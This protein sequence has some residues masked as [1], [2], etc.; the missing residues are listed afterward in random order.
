MMDG[1]IRKENSIAR[2]RSTLHIPVDR[3]CRFNMGY[4]MIVLQDVIESINNSP[5][6]EGW[7][8]GGVVE[9]GWSNRDADLIVPNPKV[10][11]SLPSYFDVIV[12]EGKPEGP[13]IPVTGLKELLALQ[14]QQALDGFR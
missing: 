1:S 12:Q 5:L 14:I 8:V 11:E 3:A 7:L 9:R 2:S 10:A 6:C 4:S 13:S